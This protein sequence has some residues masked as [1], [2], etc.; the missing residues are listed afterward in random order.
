LAN[1]VAWLKGGGF[2]PQAPTLP[3]VPKREGKNIGLLTVFHPALVIG[4]FLV[5]AT[6][7]RGAP[8]TKTNGKIGESSKGILGMGLKLPNKSLLGS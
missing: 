7:A 4:S 2:K 8:L 6:R 1:D 3:L 5:L